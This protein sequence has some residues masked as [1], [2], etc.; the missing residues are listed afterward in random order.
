M[1]HATPAPRGRQAHRLA[2]A[3][4]QAPGLPFADLL[5]TEPVAQALAQESAT[6]YARFCTP[7]APL[8]VSPPRALAPDASCRAA[9]ARSLA[10]RAAGGLPPCS[11]DT[12]AYCKA[13]GRLPEGLL[14]RLTRDT[15]RQTQDE[16]PPAWRWEGRTVKVVD[17]STVT[18]PDTPANQAA[19]PQSPA[20]QPGLGFPL[21]RLV[22]L[23]SLAVGT[24]LDAALGRCQGKQ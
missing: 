23:F 8:G 24:V 16:A 2:D 3:L 6:S 11:A 4:A 7:L 21:A 13:R 15:G 19:Y 12:S 10:G 17:G 22:V 20:Q 18:M 1:P 9:L 14:A 5:P